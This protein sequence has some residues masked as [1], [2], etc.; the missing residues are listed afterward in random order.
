MPRISTFKSINA[1]LILQFVNKIFGLSVIKHSGE[2]EEDAYQRMLSELQTILGLE[3]N[4]L[5][6]SQLAQR[7]AM[8]LHNLLEIVS[9]GSRFFLKKKLSSKK[10]DQAVQTDIR[11]QVNAACG[12][13]LT[14][15]LSSSSLDLIPKR[16]S[17]KSSPSVSVCD[18]PDLVQETPEPCS[19]QNGGSPNHVH[20]HNDAHF[21]NGSRLVRQDT[22]VISPRPPLRRV[23]TLYTELR[24]KALVDQLKEA[25]TENF[26]LELGHRL[27]EALKLKQKA[28][29]IE[30]QIDG[31]YGRDRRSI[32]AGPLREAPQVRGRTLSRGQVRRRSS[33]AKPTPV[34]KQIVQAAR[35]Q[36]NSDQTPSLDNFLSQFSS[37]LPHETRAKLKLME[38]QHRAYMSNLETDIRLQETKGTIALQDAIDRELKRSQIIAKDIKAMELFERH[39]NQV[40]CGITQEALKREERSDRAHIVRRVNDFEADA[41]SKFSA[42]R[43]REEQFV[44]S[45][46]EKRL[47]EEKISLLE[48]KK[49]IR[50][51]SEVEAKKHNELLVA[52]EGLFRSQF[53]AVRDKVADEEINL[54][55]RITQNSR[56]LYDIRRQMKENTRGLKY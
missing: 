51:Q 45:E 48:T 7:N 39:K 41:K 30:K 23:P 35:A 29:L 40:L 56:L 26:A 47:K 43:S 28:T 24:A 31:H 21:K 22:A 54:K 5:N 10:A 17:Q 25:K 6:C 33:S 42:A 36:I 13:G 12:G 14:S 20:V 27:Q 1:S 3:L 32:S 19:C 37:S 34:R 8:E 50:E 46:F 53:D 2:A 15:S 55:T 9:T 49:R 38:R 18:C 44:R 16:D 4:H 52:V 11:N